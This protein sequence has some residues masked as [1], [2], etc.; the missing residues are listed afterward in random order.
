MHNIAIA[1][2]AGGKSSRMG[3]DKA[4]VPFAGG[5]LLDYIL[6][7]LEPLALPAIIITNQPEG[8]HRFGMP[9]HA[10]IYPDWGALGGLHA[11]IHHAPAPYCLVLACDMPFISL[12]L[13]H[14]LMELAPGF[15]AVIPRLGEDAAAEP[16]RA[17]YSKT[18]LPSIERAIQRGQRRVIS[19]FDEINLC[20]MEQPEL[21]TL[22]PGLLTFFN[23][24]TPAE[25]AHAAALAAR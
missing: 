18:C 16:F 6:H 19:F 5:V 4:L 25:L 7:Q 9:L 15:D 17:I 23:V 12:P 3:T 11:A 22:D 14:R 21:E 1:I 13:L 2:Q 10:D 24:N 8:Y 20:F